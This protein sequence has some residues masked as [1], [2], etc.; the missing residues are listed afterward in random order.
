MTGRTKDLARACPRKGDDA[1]KRLLII[2]ALVTLVGCG[3]VYR[4][5]SVVPGTNDATNVRVVP[6]TAETVVQANK[7]SFEPKTLPAVFSLTAG[8]GLRTSRRRRLARTNLPGR[9]EA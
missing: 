2:G 1:V 6:I 9:N 4:S 7:S 5:S 3:T 8:T